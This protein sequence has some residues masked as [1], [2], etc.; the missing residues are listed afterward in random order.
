[1]MRGTGV[2]DMT[3][4]AID[5]REPLRVEWERSWRPCAAGAPGRTGTDGYA[6]LSTACAIQ[7]SGPGAPGV[8]PGYRGSPIVAGRPR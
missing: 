2:G 8:V 3:R 5:R 4:Y 6:A 1:M 7:R